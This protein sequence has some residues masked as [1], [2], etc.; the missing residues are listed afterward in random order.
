MIDSIAIFDDGK[1]HRETLEDRDDLR[2]YL[3]FLQLRAD[4]L[5]AVRITAPK[6][7]EQKPAGPYVNNRQGRRSRCYRCIVKS[8]HRAD[9]TM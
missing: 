1:T 8:L 4:D 3:G 9:V 2:D 6:Q 7:D 5:V